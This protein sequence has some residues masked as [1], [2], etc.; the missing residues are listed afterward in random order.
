MQEERQQTGL[1]DHVENYRD[2][3]STKLLIPIEPNDDDDFDDDDDDDD[4][5]I[6]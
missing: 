5:F 3:L 1:N 6:Q 4:E 2:K